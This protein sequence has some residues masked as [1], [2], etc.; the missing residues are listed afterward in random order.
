M[1]IA[2]TGATGFVG[3][4]LVAAAAAAGHT[5]AAL[6]RRERAAESSVTWVTG[7]LETPD[8]LARLVI[9]ADVV[10]HVAGV[11]NAPERA[12][13]FTGNVDGTRAIVTAAKDAGVSR[14]VHV[15]SLAARE[16][17]LSA[18]GASK[19]EAEGIV[20]GS[21]LD[22]DMVRPPA[23]Y[24]PGDMDML[25]LF[26]MARRGIALLPPGG[27]MSAIHVDDL[28]RLL[29]AL[30]TSHAQHRIYE[31]DD[32]RPGGWSHEAFARAIGTAIGRGIRPIALPR[33]ILQLA[34][35]VDG[36]VRGKGARLTPDRVSYFC[37]PD[38]VSDPLHRPAPDLWTPAIDT[39]QGLAD[40]AAWYR[41]RGLL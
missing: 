9:D 6:T 31:P 22:W 10:I 38:W 40:T 1:K 24:G 19:C 29:L 34:A 23:V 28:V 3:T 8:A 14:F 36:L 20:E 32:D 26:R 16:P 41:A 21:G 15:S 2:I 13:F 39:A 5:I 30:A 27:R 33:A 35:R 37:H 25:E 11:V 7:S 12:D 4:R 17:S 18:Y